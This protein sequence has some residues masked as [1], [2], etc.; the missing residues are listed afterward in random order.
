M[1]PGPRCE[2]QSGRPFFTHDEDSRGA[3][4]YLRAVTCGDLAVGFERRLELRKRLD[5]GVGA[6]ALVR[7]HDLAR[8]GDLSRLFVLVLG[9]DREDLPF[10]ATLGRGPSGVV[11][12]ASAE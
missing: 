7:R 1:K 4:G 6:D 11:L 8:L 9:S 10:K 2:P 3:I 5:R 12:T